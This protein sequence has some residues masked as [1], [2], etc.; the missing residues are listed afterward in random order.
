M[1]HD[2]AVKSIAMV[3]E[4]ILRPELWP[5]ALSSIALC[6]NSTT[7]HVQMVGPGGYAIMAGHGAEGTLQEY[8]AGGWP[9]RNS[10]MA[11]GLALTRA[12]LR[13]LITEQHMFTPEEIARDPFQNEFAHGHDIYVEAG[14]VVAEHAGWNFVINIPRGHRIGSYSDGEI[15]S[16]NRLVANL[17]NA[18]SF[19][20]KLK[21]AA[22]AD[23]VETLSHHG[24]A[25]AL[26][27]PSGRVLH[28][29]AA[30]TR[31]LGDRLDVRNG[32]VRAVNPAE[33]G[34]LQGLITAAA[35]AIASGTEP[36]IRQVVLR[37]PLGRPLI[38]RCLP[39]VGAARDFLGLARVVLA[40]DDLEMPGPA[41]VTELLCKIFGLTPSEARLAARLGGGEALREAASAEMVTFE[42]ARTRLKVIF[43]K[44]GTRRQ[45]ELAILVGRMCRFESR[46]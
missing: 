23:M 37:R 17:A 44:T 41:K 38:A 28:M 25:L 9:E 46:H 11:R 22:A 1:K 32:G 36:P 27:T 5:D 10:R 21:I 4:A 42:T 30:F 26:L 14:M 35:A 31:L 34:L 13:G 18:C 40:V 8:L 29:N 20:L 7:T 15:Q 24:E 19:A 33:D 43:D 16:M 3:N 2:D 39:V 45:T 12:G 6:C